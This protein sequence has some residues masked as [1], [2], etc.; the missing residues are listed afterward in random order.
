[1]ILR[2]LHLSD[3]H[4]TAK[5]PGQDWSASSFDQ[6]VVSKSLI[7][8]VRKQATDSKSLD[9]LIITGDIAFSGKQE[10]YEEA[11]AFCQALLAAAGLFPQHL[12]LVP[13]NHDMDRK[14]IQSVDL[15]WYAFDNQ[16]ESSEVLSNPGTFS[17]LMSKFA[18]FN[19]FAEQAMDSRY[20]DEKTYHF[21]HT[22]TLK[23]NGQ[24]CRINLAGLNSAL[25]AGY[26]D[27]D[28]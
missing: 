3:L 8:A 25:F 22:L 5:V 14:K 16:K 4:F 1:M 24:N 21:V 15:K 10:E 11:K 27:D 7:E 17:T 20:F 23:K 19:D 6:E 26:D 2:Y 13:G 28:K 12:F 18:A 9:F